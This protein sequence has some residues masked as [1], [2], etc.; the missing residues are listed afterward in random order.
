MGRA[1][2]IGINDASYQV[3]TKI[4]GKV[5]FCPFYAVWTSMLNR[6]YA[7]NEENYLD[8]VVVDAWHTFSN[9]KVWME[10]QNWQDK[11]LDKDLLIK[12][13]RIYGP[14]TCLFINPRLN[15]FLT[16]KQ[17]KRKGGNLPAGV[18]IIKSSSK[19]RVSASNG[20]GRMKHIGLFSTTEEAS[21]AYL[22]YKLS[23]AKELAKDETDPRVLGAVITWFKLEEGYYE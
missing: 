14:D 13:N 8:C 2:N 19:Y 20:N 17:P 9:F 11:Q 1:R 23:A 3:T 10:Q 7:G 15:T 22:E 18:T 5:I 21:K 6:V 16:V 4:E 12:G